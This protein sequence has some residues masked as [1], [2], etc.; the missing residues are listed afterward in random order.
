[1]DHQWQLIDLTTDVQGEFIYIDGTG[2]EHVIYVVGQVPRQI[3]VRS[4]GESGQRRPPQKDFIEAT[5][6]RYTSQ[7]RGST[8]EP[9][10]YGIEV[11]LIGENRPDLER[12]VGDWEDWHSSL[13]GQGTFK[14][15]TARGL[16]RCLDCVPQAP[17]TRWTDLWNHAAASRQEYVAANPYWRSETLQSAEG[18]CNLGTF[19]C[20]NA[21]EIPAWPTIA[22]IGQGTNPQL[23]SASGETIKV[24]KQTFNDDDEIR[25][26]CRPNS[27]TRRSAFFYEHGAGDGEALALSSDSIYWRLPVG[28]SDVTPVSEAGKP[29][30]RV[31]WYDYWESL[32]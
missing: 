10:T 30:C 3:V 9:R 26:D 12:L 8:Y 5:P 32:Y 25:I 29:G 19:A 28:V 6:D 20:D 4:G 18:I 7:Y 11:A 22:F 21:G 15:I 23:T 13:K 27:L 2:A 1:M 31:Q 14:R 24:Y 16:T 17:E